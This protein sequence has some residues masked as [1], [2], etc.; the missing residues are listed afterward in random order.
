LTL[1]KG[2]TIALII[3]L[4]LSTA[5]SI[6]GFIAKEDKITFITLVAVICAS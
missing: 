5:L 4:T 1:D 3:G 2:V 6:Y